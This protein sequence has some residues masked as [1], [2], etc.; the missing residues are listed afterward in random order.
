MGCQ[1]KL[2]CAIVYF[3]FGFDH[4]HITAGIRIR[5]ME[6]TCIYTY[7][8]HHDVNML[9]FCFAL[10]VIEIVNMYF[11]PAI[12]NPPYRGNMFAGFLMAINFYMLACILQF[13][14]FHVSCVL[15]D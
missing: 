10:C 5:M 2:E 7:H 6:Y 9:A 1:E 15:T 13:L 8:T 4:I 14:H 12:Y 11:N 3:Y